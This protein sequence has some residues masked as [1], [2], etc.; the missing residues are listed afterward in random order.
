M[1]RRCRRRVR[2]LLPVRVWGM[3]AKG[4]PFTQPA[5]VR[6]IS[7]SGALMEGMLRQVKPGEFLD[8]QVGDEKAVFKVVW[9]GKAGT[10][11]AGELGIQEVAS[12]PSIWNV[13]FTHCAEFVGKG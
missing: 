2:A 3:D 8:V 7:E 5:K 12:G 13:N 6:N 1:D 4:T 11:R 9:A 10:S